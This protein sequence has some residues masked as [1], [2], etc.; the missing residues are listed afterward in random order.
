MDCNGAFAHRKQYIIP[1]NRAYGENFED[2]AEYK[3]EGNFK[4]RLNK[5]VLQDVI[6]AVNRAKT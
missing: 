2:M 3:T 6:N 1:I 5:L 4:R